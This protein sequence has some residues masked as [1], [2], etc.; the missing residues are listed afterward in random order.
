MKNIHNITVIIA[1]TT[2]F[3]GLGLGWVFFG[4]TSEG[5]HDH[6]QKTT[7]KNEVWTCSMHPQIRMP[8]PGQCPICGM[9]LIP[10]GGDKVEGN[11]LEIKMSPT[12]MQLANVQTQ[13]VKK[14]KPIKKLHLNGKIQ[15]DERNV[16]SQTAHIGGRVEQ[17]FINYTGEYVNKGQV[18]GTIY[19]PDL[20]N[21]QE[22]LFQASKIKETQPFLFEAAQE[23]LRNWKLSDRQIKE[24]LKSGKAKENFPIH[25]DQSGVVSDKMVS[26]G[27]YI[28][29]GTVLYEIA[30]LSSLWILFDVYESDLP[31]IKKGDKIHYTVQSLPGEMFSGKISFIDPVINAKTRV[32]KARLVVNNKSDQ[33]KPE[34][35]VS[36]TLQTPLEKGELRIVVP[37]TAVMW[38]GEKSIVYVKS[39]EERGVNFMMREVVLGH[40][41]GD[42]YIISAGLEEGEEIVINGTFSIDAAAQLAGKPSMMNPME[43]DAS[44]SSI[45]PR[46]SADISINEEAKTQLQQLSTTYLKL[47]DDLVKDDFKTV[48][49]D[50]AQLKKILQDV[51]MKNFQGS[52]KDK[53]MSFHTTLNNLLQHSQQ[54]QSLEEVRVAFIAISETM[55]RLLQTFDFTTEPLYVQHCPMA[56]KDEGADWI[57]SEKDI[58]NPY[59]GQTMI[60][61]GEVKSMLK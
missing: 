38:T 47:K 31:W 35:F 41:L 10:V 49:V 13:L 17:L 26:L 27:D 29:P 59:F 46:E 34:M 48:K 51:D 33:L 36:G 24:I 16:Y 9:D 45:L 61:C 23:K 44:L 4:K 39:S 25:A 37:K 53:W 18:I 55:I 2:L 15:A 1:L 32:A 40:S 50:L 14:E 19:S 3:I 56:N 42:S 52:A 8:E 60:S 54:W 28:Q 20:V 58:R 43:S 30:N 11:V 5:E 12:A 21:A 22:E 6:G 7:S 57:S